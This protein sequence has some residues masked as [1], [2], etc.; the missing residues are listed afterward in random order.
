MR[1][2]NQLGESL[3]ERLIALSSASLSGY[4]AGEL[5]RLSSKYMGFLNEAGADKYVMNGYSTAVNY[6][7]RD[8]D[9]KLNTQV[10]K[11][12][13][14]A[15]TGNEWNRHCITLTTDHGD[16]TCDYVIVTV[17]LGCL[18]H[19]A[20]EFEPALPSRKQK[21]IDRLGAG[22]YNASLDIKFHP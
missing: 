8:L 6:L 20:V 11:I 16:M 4:Y 1:L 2:K 7:A 3:Y 19:N 12:T 5:E 9:V 17:P 21:A 13:Y 22:T 10:R 15:K 18:K 14:K